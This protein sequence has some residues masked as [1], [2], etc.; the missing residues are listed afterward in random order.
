MYANNSL[1]VIYCRDL[2]AMTEFYRDRVGM[3]TL[4]EKEGEQVLVTEAGTR[5]ILQQAEKPAVTYAF[6]HTDIEAAHAALGDLGPG[7]ITRHPDGYEFHMK[8]PEGNV[9]EFT[10]N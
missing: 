7:E 4:A 1:T 2:K 9:V 8:D 5:L 10:S 6:T 3:K